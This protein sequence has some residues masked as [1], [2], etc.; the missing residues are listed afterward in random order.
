MISVRL[1]VNGS[2]HRRDVEPRLLLVHFLRDVCGLTGTHV[3]CETGICGACTVLVDGKRRQVLHDV[4][5]AGRRRR[6][7]RPSKASRPAGTCI[8][9]SRASGSATA[10]SA[11]SARPGMIMAVGAAAG[12]EREPD[13][14]RDRPRLCTAIC[15]AAPATRTSSMPSNTP[16]G[17]PA[18]GRWPDELIP[19]RTPYVGRAMKRVEDPRLIKGIGTYTDDLRLPGLLHARSCAARTRTRA[20]TKIDTQRRAGACPASWRS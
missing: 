20:S 18:D 3:G 13:A 8:R 7:S 1:R 5:R 10:C 14:R 15:A 9:F 4:R 11:A 6:Q 2:E 17:S 12:T 16:L 19:T